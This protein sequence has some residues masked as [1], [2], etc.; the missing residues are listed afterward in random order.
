MRQIIQIAHFPQFARQFPGGLPPMLAAFANASAEPAVADAEQQE[1]L[2]RLLT[3]TPEHRLDLLIAH[4][5]A[6]VVAVLNLAPAFALDLN[7]G[8]FDLG[9]DSL[10]ALEVRN[11]L[12]RSLGLS[13][14][15]TVVFEHVTVLG[16]ASYVHELL[17]PA[18]PA[19][20]APAAA[21]DSAPDLARLLAEIEDLSD[22][23]VNDTLAGWADDR[24]L[25]GPST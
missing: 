8:L 12:Q 21:P 1:L 11:H 10:T 2:N 23:E 24:P 16:L 18:T 19:V 14:P 5:R 25:E 17:A 4:V 13:L 15:A 3:T 6:Q 22:D 9:M 7:Q 20:P